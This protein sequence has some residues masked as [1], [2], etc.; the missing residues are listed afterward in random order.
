MLKQFILLTS[1]LFQ[2]EHYLQ[3]FLLFPRDLWI[4]CPIF[5]SISFTYHKFSSRLISGEDRDH[6]I[7]LVFLKSFFS[8]VGNIQLCGIWSSIILQ[9]YILVYKVSWL[10]LKPFKKT[11]KKY[12]SFKDLPYFSAFM[13][14]SSTLK[15]P[16]ILLPTVLT[17]NILPPLLCLGSRVGFFSEW[18][19]SCPIIIS[20]QF[21]N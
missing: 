9:D 4:M 11:K 7:I 2:L 21:Y 15:R 14:I 6:S 5:M 20:I 16:I 10:Q 12:V 19:T 13:L 1:P 8:K 18:L 17:Q 3:Q